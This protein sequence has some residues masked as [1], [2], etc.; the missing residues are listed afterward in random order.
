M[1]IAAVLLAAGAGTRFGSAKQLA[2]VDGEPLVHRAATTAL[3]SGCSSVRVIVGAHR[4]QVEAA[5]AGLDV[6]IVANPSWEDG[7]ASSIRVGIDAVA[8]DIP[9]VEAAILLLADQVSVTPA[10][11]D[12]LIERFAAGDADLVACAYAGTQGPPALFGRRFFAELEELRGDR[13]ARSVLSA[14]HGEL[15]LVDFP[16]GAHD[17]DTPADLRPT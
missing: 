5:L 8:A 4:E 1:S 14:H 11:L 15:A 16:E 2:E 10:V 7:M 6:L 12:A 9:R 3:A 17:V 13:G